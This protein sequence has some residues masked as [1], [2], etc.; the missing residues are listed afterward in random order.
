MSLV[1]RCPTCGTA[2][3]VQAAQLSAQSGTVRCG[4]CGELFNGVAGLVE[5]AEEG[6]ALE[7]S[8]QLGLFD[9]SRRPQPGPAEDAPPPPFMAEPGPR[10]T[11]LWAL[12]ALLAFLSLSAQVAH[13]YRA[14]LAAMLPATRE[15]LRALCRPLAC[16]VPL[17]RRPE[18]MSIDSSELQAD[19][20]REGLISLSAVI[21]NRAAFAQDYPSLE[22]TL[23]DEADRPVLR[24]VLAPRDYLG[25]RSRE[26]AARGI[27]PASEAT[28]RVYLDTGR[29]RAT[30]YRLYLF[31]PS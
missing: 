26:A 4:K 17:P 7:P 2:F 9:P 20:R 10:R 6:L 14:E 21:R 16:D 11:W 24:R 28:A 29:V 19:P 25:E 13:R 22:L 8:P 30:G 5:P 23:T 31:Y 12:L 3:R 27:P 1:T 18:L 15:A